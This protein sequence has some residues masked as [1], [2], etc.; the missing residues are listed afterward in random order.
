[1]ETAHFSVPSLSEDRQA[2]DLG[3]ALT[4]VKGVAAIR[5]DIRA[6]TVTVDYDTDFTDRGVLKTMIE[7][8]GYPLEGGE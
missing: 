3:N 8:A 2:L 7:Q 4:A 6:H 1:M 5:S